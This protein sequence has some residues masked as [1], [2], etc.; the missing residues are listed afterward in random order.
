MIKFENEQNGRFYYL[1]EQ[2]DIT[3]E[4]VLVCIRG[5]RNVSLTRTVGRGSP[6]VIQA[7]IARLTKRRIRRGYTLVR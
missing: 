5:G 4:L 7:E 1:K 3:G 2:K 6:A